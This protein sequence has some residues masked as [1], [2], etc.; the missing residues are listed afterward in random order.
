MTLDEAKQLREGRR[1]VFTNGVFDVLHIGHVRYL[2]EARRLGDL[3]LVG[4]NSDESV[5]SLKGPTRPI[6]PTDERIAMLEALRMVDGAIEFGEATPVEIIKALTP[7]VHVKG[8][9]Y[10][11]SDMPE[12]PV[13]QAYGGQVLILP[14]VPNRSTSRLLK[15]LGE[16]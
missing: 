5:R 16:E 15:L 6:N 8:G 14:L 2:Q 11:A 9:D 7:E 10:E 12:T 3:L 13:V 1:L 4:V